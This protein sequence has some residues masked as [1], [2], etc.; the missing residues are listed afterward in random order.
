MRR[1]YIGILG[2][3]LFVSFVF[4]AM[5]TF[6]YYVIVSG[7]TSHA[8]DQGHISFFVEGSP[9][10]TNGTTG[11]SS[12]GGGGGSASLPSTIKQPSFEAG[13]E[14][15]NLFMV[16][17]SEQQSDVL[18]RNTGTT[19]ITLTLSLSGL[20]GIASLPFNQLTLA[21]GESKTLTLTVKSPDSGVYAGRI[22][23]KSDSA[24]KDIFVLVN[25]RSTNALFDVSLAIPDSYKR[26]GLGQT[27][28]AFISLLQVGP[29]SQTD[30]SIVYSVKDFDGATLQTESETFRV[31]RSKNFVKSFK[32]TSLEA[33]DYVIAMEVTYPD[34]FASASD[35]FT[36][37]AT[38]VD[39]WLIISIVLGIIAAGAII[40]SIL[41]YKRSRRISK[42]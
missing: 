3:L 20:T 25:V 16:A 32:T 8:S 17:N 28:K 38:H 33:G 6:S 31:F 37:S 29:A 10:E 27:L 7:L 5:S 34:G 13:P 23:I 4:L 15:L 39:M 26:L 18:I 40:Y 1:L 24:Q 19:S 42:K 11:G 41:N 30:V 2:A 22:T 12:G 9:P 35:H 14:E 21:P 36:I